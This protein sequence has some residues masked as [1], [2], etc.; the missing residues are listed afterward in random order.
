MRII[1]DRLTRCRAPTILTIFYPV[2]GTDFF[3][4]ALAIA[5][6]VPFRLPFAHSRDSTGLRLPGVVGPNGGR[7]LILSP[8][9]P[10]T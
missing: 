5:D 2:P 8:F 9:I 4:R 10:G 3:H 6:R 1:A 7:T